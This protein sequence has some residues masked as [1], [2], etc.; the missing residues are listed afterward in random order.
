MV[1]IFVS[2]IF[3]T[4][5]FEHT[6]LT[7][8]IASKRNI[9]MI[10]QH[11]LPFIA[12]RVISLRL[13]DDEDTP[14]Q[15]D[16]F[17]SYIPLMSQ[18]THL[19]SL[20]LY[21][22]RSSEILVK[23]VGELHHLRNLTHLAISGFCKNNQTD[24][25]LIANNIWSLPKLT[26]Y[27]TAIYTGKQL[28]FFPSKKCSPCLK[29]LYISDG[30]TF[31]CGQI[32]QLFEYTPHLKRLTINI[33]TD[34]NEDYKS[35]PLPALINLSIK[36]YR[37]CENS[38]LLSFLQ[39]VRNLRCLNISL[40]HNLI[41]GHRWEQLIR[42]YLP[43]LKIFQ[44]RMRDELPVNQNIEERADE[45]INSFR[46]SFWTDEHKW[47]VRCFTC[48]KTIY[49]QTLFKNVS[50]SEKPFPDLFRS[51]Y[52][53]DDH[54][55][56]YNTLSSIYD[57]EFFNLPIPSYIRLYNIDYLSMRFPVED[58]FRT[59]VPSLK[60]LHS[61]NISSHNDTFQSQLQALLDDASCLKR[62]QISQDKQLPLQTSLFKYTSTS[63]HQL[64]LKYYGHF[65]NEKEC[66][67][68]SHSPL[69][70]QCKVLFIHVKNHESIPI[71]I[72][73]M[74]NLRALYVNCENIKDPIQ[75]PP[76]MNYNRSEDVATT[77]YREEIIKWLNDRLL[78]KCLFGKDLDSLNYIRIWI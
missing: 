65:F 26:D 23:I 70:R 5:N 18:Y 78:F 25:D 37:V 39:N 74:N 27:R 69:G 63:V 76:L 38:T 53:H 9:D 59:V 36:S 17:F 7:F 49:L 75:I 22:F 51:T 13:F 14:G 52:P 43:K 33:E 35:S 11:H 64:T 12:D 58:Q 62:L 2:I 41:D 60:K 34:G 10:C 16:V 47:F 48:V 31:K 54:Q 30:F 44:L 6:I 77:S 55:K 61:L 66:V 32:Y 20:T 72:Q 71:L 57:T 40:Y 1:L 28:T 24:M 8:L 19:R 68:L 29:H 4:N 73:N 15:I 3:S 50:Y 46:S 42:N 67:T 56:F 45:L 21:R